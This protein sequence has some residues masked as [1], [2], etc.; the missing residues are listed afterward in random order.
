VG[1]REELAAV[2]SYLSD[3][4]LSPALDPSGQPADGPSAESRREARVGLYVHVPFCARRCSYCDFA[5]GTISAAAVERYLRAIELESARRAQSAEGI[6]FSS[7]F[8]GGGTP[9]ALSA[10]HFDRLWKS[11]SDHFAIEPNAERTLEANPETVRPALL[12]A[13][14][15]AGVNRL[16]MGAQSFDADELRRLGRIHDAERPGVALDMAQ[17][18]GFHRLSLDLMFGYPGHRAG[19]WSAT[20]DKALSLAPEHLSAYCFIPEED[21]P[22]GGATLRGETT[23]P[24]PEE[25]ADLY[26]LLTERLAAHGYAFYETSNFCRPEGECRHN[27]VYWLRRDY[28]SLGPS[29]HGLWRGVR[30]AN[31]RDLGAWADALEQ[32]APWDRQEWETEDSCAEETVML[33]LRLGTGLDAADHSPEPWRVLLERYASALRHG[34]ET[35]RLERTRSGYRIPP[36]HRFVADEVIAWLMVESERMQRAA[37]ARSSLPVYL[38]VRQAAP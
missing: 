25:Q 19:T 24:S 14:A 29:A 3:H 11:I 16:S 4:P 23:L 12:D 17:R 21:T 22:L 9:S 26:Q 28:L 1:S 37:W 18:H 31:H 6:R 38:T 5:T 34:V 8:L 32:E 15:R 20:L 13:W 2:E 10:R 33:A 27:L 30:Y 7:V 36:R 35:G